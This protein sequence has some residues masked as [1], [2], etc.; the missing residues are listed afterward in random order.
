MPFRTRLKVCC[1]MSAEEARLAVAHGA[2]AVGLVAQMPSGPGVIADAQ[3][4]A[5]VADVPPPV[6]TFL[7]TSE[8]TAEGIADHVLRTRPSAVQLVSHVDPAVHGQL[9]RLLPSVRIVQVIHVEDHGSVALARDY[10]RLADVLLLDSGR[11]KAAIAELG[12]TGRVHDWSLSRSIVESVERPVFLAGGL[13]PVNVA[14]AVA[15]VRPFG[16]DLCSG[17]RTNGRLD[18][19]KLGALVAAILA[20]DRGGLE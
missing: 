9:K 10:A 19:G 14:E 6:A 3:I 11:P 1:I 13:N 15:L 16:L 17:V 20:A 2:D 4:E 8:T 5:I 7:L 18:P 12:G